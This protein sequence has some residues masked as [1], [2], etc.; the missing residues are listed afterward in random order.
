VQVTDC[1]INPS[2]ALKKLKSFLTTRRLMD[3]PCYY[4]LQA[5]DSISSM[6]RLSL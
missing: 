1:N 2:A 4:L 5:A 6:E 3:L